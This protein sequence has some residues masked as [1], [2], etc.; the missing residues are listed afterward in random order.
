MIR[1]IRLIFLIACGTALFTHVRAQERSNQ[2]TPTYQFEFRLSNKSDTVTTLY[3]V[4]RD[5]QISR[6]I[7]VN[8]TYNDK[9][10]QY[11][12][13]NILMDKSAEFFLLDNMVFI[14]IME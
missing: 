12:T 8:V 14:K 13:K 2:I 1:I 11:F 5:E 3:C 6:F 4:I 10:R 9:T 7:K